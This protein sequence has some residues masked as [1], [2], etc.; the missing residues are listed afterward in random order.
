MDRE[1]NLHSA[2]WSASNA[3]EC[4]T[5]RNR[6]KQEGQRKCV[7]RCFDAQRPQLRPASGPDGNRF[8][9]ANRGRLSSHS[10]VSDR[11]YPTYRQRSLSLTKFVGNSQ[12]RAQ[13]VV[14]R[15]F[16]T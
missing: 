5:E 11:R 16:A 9:L 3:K 8:R 6:E 12:F 10:I 1:R 15:S 14:E 7:S 2:S 4:R 13:G